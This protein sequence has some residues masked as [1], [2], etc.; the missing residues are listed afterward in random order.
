MKFLTSITVIIAIPTMVASFLG[1]NV[2][3][4]FETGI[5]GFHAVMIVSI[6]VTILAALW[7]KKK[8]MF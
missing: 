1:M 2:Q 8:D 7:L 4:P 3:F 6:V 5:N